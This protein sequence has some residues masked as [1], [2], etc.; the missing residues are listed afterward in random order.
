ML[1]SVRW[2]VTIKSVFLSRALDD[3]FWYVHLHSFLHGHRNTGYNYHTCTYV[4]AISYVFYFVSSTGG[5][6]NGTQNSLDP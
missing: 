3:I 4:I 6:V 5:R 1:L 2:W